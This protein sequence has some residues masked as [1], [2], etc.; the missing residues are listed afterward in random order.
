MI[1]FFSNK[2][3]KFIISTFFGIV[4]FFMMY[5]IISLLFQRD[6]SALS[7]DKFAWG[8]SFIISVYA[9]LCF[10]HFISKYTSTVQFLQTI[11]DCINVELFNNVP[12]KESGNREDITYNPKQSDDAFK[13]ILQLRD[14]D[15]KLMWNRINLLLVFQGVLIAAVAAGIENL[16]SAKY[17]L[18]FAAIIFFGFFSSLMLFNIARGGSWWVSHWEQ[19]LAKIEPHFV[20]DIDIFREHISTKPELKRIWKT[21]GY[22]S[23]RDTIIQFTSVFPL[24]WAIIFLIFIIGSPESTIENITVCCNSSC[25]LM[26]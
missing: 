20:G 17:G 23:T 18:L 8:L 3:R 22:V 2:K 26:K 25:N 4:I 24:V 9:F 10:Y 5:F 1:D 13:I 7:N 16:S 21:Q 6:N 12:E 15:N 14:V 11:K 19:H